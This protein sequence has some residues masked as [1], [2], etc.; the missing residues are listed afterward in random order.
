MFWALF[1]FFRNMTRFLSGH[2]SGR[3]KNSRG[4]EKK[5]EQLD[6]NNRLKMQLLNDKNGTLRYVLAQKSKQ[7]VITYF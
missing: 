3:R 7:Q 5:T 6:R 1:F 4:A 2:V